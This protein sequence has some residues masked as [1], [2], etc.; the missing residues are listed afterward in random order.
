MNNI[1][2]CFTR[3]LSSVAPGKSC[4]QIC[5]YASLCRYADMQICNASLELTQL[6]QDHPLSLSPFYCLW[7]PCQDPVPERSYQ[8]P[9]SQNPKSNTVTPKQ[10]N[11][12]TNKQKSHAGCQNMDRDTLLYLRMFQ[13]QELQATKARRPEGKEKPRVKVRSNKDKLRN[14][15]LNL[16]LH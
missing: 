3:G 11:K 10:T 1:C 12:Q 4:L 5:R 15:N 9:E 13:S 16:Q 6:L 14:Q 8:L 7:K 2:H